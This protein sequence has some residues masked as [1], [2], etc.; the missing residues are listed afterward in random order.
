MPD[1][2]RYGDADYRER[3]YDY[4]RDID[5]DYRR[6]R[7]RLFGGRDLDERGERRGF[8]RDERSMTTRRDRDD[9]RF[10]SDDRHRGLPIDETGRLIASNKVDGTPVYS[11]D[12]ERLGSIYNFMV[13]K[14]TGQVEYAVMTYGGFLG[15]GVRYYPLPW[16]ILNYDTRDG[17][18]RIH[19]RARDFERAPSFGRDDE[20]RF[21]REYG[22]RVNDWYGLEY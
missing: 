18:Y 13:D 14:F 15:M 3:D 8:F 20:P 7:R 5:R 6:G 11:R 19:L 10:G 22:R 12:G 9:D 21:S 17:G 16:R 4:E 2:G 1:F